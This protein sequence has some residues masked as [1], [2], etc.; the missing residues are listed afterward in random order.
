MPKVDYTLRARIIS[1]LSGLPDGY[2]F[3]SAIP[4]Y[5]VEEWVLS[6]PASKREA[7]MIFVERIGKSK[8]HLMSGS[9]WVPE[10]DRLM[11]SLDA[12][13]AQTVGDPG[14]SPSELGHRVSMDKEAAASRQR[15]IS[16][17]IAAAD[18]AEAE[19]GEAAVSAA[20]L[21]PNASTVRVD[22]TEDWD[23]AEA[24]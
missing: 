22:E 20:F 1:V 15:S 21:R 9:G 2:A 10:A 11:R 24:Q 5:P 6:Q 7:A 13:V 16:E 3:V 14:L 23:D 17:K 12:E 8:P 18:D 19:A 4:F